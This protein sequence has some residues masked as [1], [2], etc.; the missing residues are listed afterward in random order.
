MK[1]R[2]LLIA[3][4][5][6]ACALPAAAGTLET[7]RGRGEMICGVSPGVAGFSV[8][9]EAGRWGGFDVDICRAVAAAVFGD[10]GKVRYTPLSPKDRFVSLQSSEIDM[11]S[12]QATWTLSRDTQMG[13]RYVGIGYYDGQGFMVRKSLNIKSAKELNGA[14]VCV[15]TGTT[16]ELN[17]ADYFRANGM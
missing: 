16:T 6:A 14:S 1:T 17:I 10:A 13:L 8:P 5:M 4:L 2:L 3:G 7:V 15:P 9:D 12:R 11:L